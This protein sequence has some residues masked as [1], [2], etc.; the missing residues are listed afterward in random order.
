M[1]GQCF[2]DVRI[3]FGLYIVF[4]SKVLFLQLKPYPLDLKNDSEYG[5]YVSLNFLI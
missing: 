5:V 1:R 2:P 3:K 4:L